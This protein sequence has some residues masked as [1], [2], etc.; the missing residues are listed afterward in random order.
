[1]ARLEA[2]LLTSLTLT[3]LHG[4]LVC[5]SLHFPLSL[6]T[7]LFFKGPKS[8]GLIIL[9][10]EL[11][12]QTVQCF[13]DAFPQIKANGWNIVSQASMATAGGPWVNLSPDGSSVLPKGI[14]AGDLI[15]T[16]T[17]AITNVAAARSVRCPDVL[18]FAFTHSQ[19][20]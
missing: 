19:S 9:E 6:P 1:L 11:T 18:C 14:L 16:P 5:Y 3:S 10:H 17:P 20:I 4:S 7:L 15:V 2:Q 13:I 12:N 8:P